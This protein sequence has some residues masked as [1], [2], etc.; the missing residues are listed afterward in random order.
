MNNDPR[1][2]HEASTNGG[3]QKNYGFVDDLSNDNIRTPSKIKNNNAGVIYSNPLE[4]EKR[5]KRKITKMSRQRYRR[6][7]RGFTVLAIF[8]ALVL[9]ISV[10]FIIRTRNDNP[11]GTEDRE[12]ETPTTEKNDSILTEHVPETD[13]EANTDAPAVGNSGSTVTVD[14]KQI[15]T[16]ELILVNYKYE[17]IFPEEDIL[18][19]M[20]D[21]NA[22]YS[23]STTETYIQKPALDAF[24]ELMNDLYENSGCDDVIV[25]SA[26][27]SVEKQQSI[28]QD[29][30]DR[31]GS[32]Y[33]AAYVADPGYSEHHT[34][35]AM[36]LSI[37]TENGLT[38][39]IED[40]SECKWFNENYDRYG[41]ILRYPE[42]KAGITSINYEGWHYRYVGLPHSIIMDKLN[43]CLEEYIDYLRAYTVDSK[44]LKYTSNGSVITDAKYGDE[45]SSGDTIIYYVPASDNETT[46][47]PVPDG[48]TPRISGNN[49]DGFI[50][51][52]SLYEN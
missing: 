42:D 45:I 23:V 28:Y 6:Q 25:V 5:P 20:Y 3:Q 39:D 24:S 12:I 26:Y 19:S 51:T 15:H 11:V 17:Y 37:Y 8:L 35:L 13:T 30:L 4:D 33:A 9:A 50:V 49:V 31:Y 52:A 22:L 1:K 21:K 46:D 18:V 32:E 40:Y 47:I 29:R 43:L 41:Y 38:Y 10:Y 36:D 2:N 34:G 27:R 7:N 16:V 48:V 14:N 44:V